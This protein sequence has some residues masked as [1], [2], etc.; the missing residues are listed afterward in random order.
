MKRYLLFLIFF[1]LSKGYSLSFCPVSID[2]S[3]FLKN[4]QVFIFKN[5]AIYVGKWKNKK[6]NGKGILYFEDGSIYKGTFKKNKITGFGICNYKDG[7]IYKGFWKNGF[8]NGKGIYALP[9]GRIIEAIFVKNQIIKILSSK[10]KT[11]EKNFKQPKNPTA[12]TP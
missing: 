8:W 5:G 1:T 2:L 10:G 12:S 7:S 11:N 4:K 6:M 9:D 3:N